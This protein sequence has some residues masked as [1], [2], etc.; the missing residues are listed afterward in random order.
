MLTK[1]EVKLQCLNLACYAFYNHGGATAY[2]EDGKSSEPSAND[3]L[4][5]AKLMYEW[6]SKDDA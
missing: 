6:V 1:E 2:T 3:F 4:D 5:K